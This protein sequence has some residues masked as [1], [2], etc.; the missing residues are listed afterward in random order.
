VKKEQ[1]IDTD[2]QILTKITYSKYTV[3]FNVKGLKHRLDGP[4]YIGSDGTQD[5]W[6][7]DKLHRIG[8]PAVSHTEG[9]QLYLV[10]DKLHHIEGPAVVGSDGHREYWINGIEYTKED[11][12]KAVLEYKL[13]QLV[14]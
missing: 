5:Y 2:G 10:D 4:A 9:F 7:N 12:P 13:K 6:I 1:I 8:G 11:Y 3:Y 14:G